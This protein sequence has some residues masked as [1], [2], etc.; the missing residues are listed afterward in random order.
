MRV[1]Y[2]RRFIIYSIIIAILGLLTVNLNFKKND[3]YQESKV[4]EE[5]S[6]AINNEDNH[7]SSD[8]QS[9]ETFNDNL[10]IDDFEK[11]DSD[12]NS[13]LYLDY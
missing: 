12:D 13:T 11:L 1:S 9:V 3:I 7:I 10:N 5:T 6:D 8:V 4:D 2:K